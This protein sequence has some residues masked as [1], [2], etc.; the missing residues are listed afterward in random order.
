MTG[1]T[2]AADTAFE[3]PTIDLLDG[4][5]VTMDICESCFLYAGRVTDLDTG[6]S[7]RWV[8]RSAVVQEHHPLYQQIFDY[9]DGAAQIGVG[10][11]VDDDDMVFGE[12]E[13]SLYETEPDAAALT[14]RQVLR[15]GR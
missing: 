7:W 3:L 15:W 11:V 8:Y 6:Q 4:R 14:V 1:S 13:L 10:A 5:S 12:A 2:G 9:L